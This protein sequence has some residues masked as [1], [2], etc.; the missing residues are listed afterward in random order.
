MSTRSHDQGLICVVSFC[1]HSNFFVGVIIIPIIQTGKMEV[2]WFK[3]PAFGLIACK[4]KEDS[5]QIG[6]GALMGEQR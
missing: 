6:M 5:I 4:M 1:H 3:S 2:R